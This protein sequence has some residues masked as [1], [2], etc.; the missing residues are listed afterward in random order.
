MILK[1]LVFSGITRFEREVEIDFSD[2]PPGLVAVAAGNGQGKTTIL[3]CAGPGAM[4]RSM[5]FYARPGTSARA[6]LADCCPSGTA[7]LLLEFERDGSHWSVRHRLRPDRAEA[8]LERDGQMLVSGKVRDFDAQIEKHFGPSEVFL[9]S[10]FGVQ[11]GIGR[12]AS[13]KP[14]ERKA[15]FAHFLAL[16]RLAELREKATEEAKEA[17][18]AFERMQTIGEDAPWLEKKIADTER[19]LKEQDLAVKSLSTASQKARETL[20]GAKDRLDA[21]K[22]S[23]AAQDHRTRVARE[24]EVRYAEGERLVTR[25]KELRAK[26]G[27]APA[28][29]PDVRALEQVLEDARG[30]LDDLRLAEQKVRTAKIAAEQAEEDELLLRDV[31]CNAEGRFAS[32]R[33]LGRAVKAR[34]ALP[35]LRKMVRTLEKEQKACPRPEDDPET[36]KIRLTRARED[37]RTFDSAQA[38]RDEIGRIEKQMPDLR[39]AVQRLKDSLDALP[40]GEIDPKEEEALAAL[41]KADGDALDALEIGRRRREGIASEIRTHRES[42]RRLQEREAECG[43]QARDLPV[44]RWLSDALGPN[45]L[46]AYEIDL[47]APEI[48]SIANDL[49]RPCFD[50]RF[51]LSIDTGREKKDGGWAD[52]LALLVADSRSGRISDIAGFSGGEQVVCDEALRSALSIFGIRRTGIRQGT[53]YRDEASGALDPVSAVA[54]VAMLRRTLEVGGFKHLLFVAHDP[55]VVSMADAVVEIAPDGSVSTRRQG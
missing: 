14:T 38:A 4:Y 25:R 21:L 12:L 1:R 33:F 32:C 49:L 52:D 24:L 42:L 19:A 18:R 39:D 20:D 40:Q 55:T 8:Y 10:V 47:A 2:L 5:P 53:L 54:Y 11:G 31:P 30:M 23:Y 36:T 29:R 44:L 41:E 6:S 34:D 50:G 13:M 45:G 7:D 22:A 17:K 43:D 51:S 3:Q 9:A 37:A 26:I 35:D 15:V 28:E 48:A 27:D 16:H 46:Q